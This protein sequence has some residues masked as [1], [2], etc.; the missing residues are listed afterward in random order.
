MTTIKAGTVKYTANKAFPA[1]DNE[2]RF[3]QNLVRLNS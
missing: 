1:Q 3:K 2:G